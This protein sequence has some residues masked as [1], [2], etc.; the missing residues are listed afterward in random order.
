MFGTHTRVSHIKCLSERLRELGSDYKLHLM[1][2]QLNVMND[3]H[4][5]EVYHERIDDKLVRGHQMLNTERHLTLNKILLWNMT[6][7]KRIVY[8][9]PDI[10][11]QNLPERLMHSNITQSIAAVHGCGGFFNSGFIVLTPDTLIFN[12]ML[13]TFV[14]TKY[15]VACDRSKDRD[16][17]LLNHIFQHDWARLDSYWNFPTHYNRQTNYTA[18][19]QRKLNIHFVAEHKPSNLCDTSNWKR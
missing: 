10:Y 4:I 1:T 11:I 5:A 19:L 17:S 3:S 2:D 8:L 18:L 14:D 16:Q 15:P 9:D 7:F 12:N 6:N 13:S